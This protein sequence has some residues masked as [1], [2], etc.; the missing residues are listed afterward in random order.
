M[1]TLSEKRANRHA[2]QNDNTR[3][4]NNNIENQTLV[5]IHELERLNTAQVDGTQITKN[6]ITRTQ[7]N[8]LTTE[9][10]TPH[11]LWGTAIDCN[12]YSSIRVMG[13]ATDAFLI[14]GSIDDVTYYKMSQVNPDTNPNHLYHF[15][16]L[17]E[18]P[19]R[20][21]KIKNGSSTITITLDYSLIN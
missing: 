20:Y 3:I 1:S 11:T 4:L 16:D 5:Q 17:L 18:N 21:I 13:I 2:L 15:N 7:A 9:T 14:Y 19:P 8:L 10:L 12:E 6:K